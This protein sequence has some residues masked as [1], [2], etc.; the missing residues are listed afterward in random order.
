M[1]KYT[2]ILVMVSLL[3]VCSSCA[4]IGAWL[5]FS[6]ADSSP[7]AWLAG[8]TKAIYMFATPLSIQ[9]ERRQG[10]CLALAEPWKETSFPEDFH[11]KGVRNALKVMELPKPL[12]DDGRYFYFQED[13]LE[14]DKGAGSHK[15]Y[16]RI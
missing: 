14:V 15:G 11:Q 7:A 16:H 2:K 13:C 3:M 12:E 1:M 4:Y 8:S 5:V 6:N 9:G 10:V